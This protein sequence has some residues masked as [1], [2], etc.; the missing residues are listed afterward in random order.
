ML[1]YFFSQVYFDMNFFTRT[2]ILNF[3]SVPTYGL[4]SSQY[5]KRVD[6]PTQIWSYYFSSSNMEEVTID[7]DP[8][9]S[10]T[11]GIFSKKKRNLLIKSTVKQILG[12]CK[13][14]V[15][16]SLRVT[17]LI[18]IYTCVLCTCVRY[19][20]LYCVLVYWTCNS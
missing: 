2:I 11:G 7:N 14:L 3:L 18:T 20:I 8:L 16:A 5:Y 15:V 4:L 13:S 19:I 9:N 10:G 1:K 17:L 12:N 6:F